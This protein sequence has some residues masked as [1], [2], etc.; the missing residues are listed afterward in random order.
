MEI[1]LRAVVTRDSM[2]KRVFAM[3]E[4]SVRLSVCLSV[5][6]MYCV[7]TTQLRIMKSSLHMGCRKNSSFL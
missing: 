3:A 2:S 7:K 1:R 5:T 6:L 4:A